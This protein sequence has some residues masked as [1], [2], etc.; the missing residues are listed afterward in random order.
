MWILQAELLVAAAVSSLLFAV[1][2]LP[3]SEAADNAPVSWDG[4]GDGLNWTDCQNWTADTCPAIDANVT[5]VP[6]SDVDL[7]SS[8]ILKGSR[9]TIS[10]GATL[11]V[12]SG[13]SLRDDSRDSIL[14]NDGT[15]VISPSAKVYWSGLL[16]NNAEGSI[17]NRGIFESCGHTIN[18]GTINNKPAASFAVECG[19]AFENAGRFY[20]FGTF[21]NAKEANLEN[22]GTFINAAEFDNHAVF[23]NGGL[24]RSNGTLTND[25]GSNFISGACATFVNSGTL[26]GGPIQSGSGSCGQ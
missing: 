4:G 9:L 23:R 14:S 1:F 20:N 19:S 12:L 2:V 8:V 18:D 5:L 6:G 26:V 25:A 17:N 13:I 7:D 11:N 24:F 15:I 3:P 10:S 21:I 22:L 16:N